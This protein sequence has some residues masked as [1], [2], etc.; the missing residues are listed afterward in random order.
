[1]TT[2]SLTILITVDPANG[3]ILAAS[4]AR[5]SEEAGG[6]TYRKDE[7]LTVAASAMSASLETAVASLAAQ[8]LDAD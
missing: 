1:M 8:A 4:Y 3:S 6:A 2:K 5:I 7:Q